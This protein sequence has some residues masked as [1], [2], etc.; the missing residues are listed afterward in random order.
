M[1][2]LALTLL[3]AFFL[4]SS[5]AAAKRSLQGASGLEL[6][7]V[8]LSLP[9]LLLAPW[10]FLYDL[11]SLP[12]VFWG[13]LALLTPLEILAMWLYVRA[14]R[15][16]PLALT[17][18]YLAFTP[19]LVVVTGRL[20][21]DERISTVGLFGILLVVAGSWLLNF[22][23]GGRLSAAR[24]V[25]P[26]RAIVT[27]PGSRMMLVTAALYAMTSV[28]GKAAM[29]WLPPEPF[30]MLYFGLVGGVTL[31]LVTAA[32]PGA[33]RVVRHGPLMVFVVGGLMA[34]M[35][36]TH[37]MALAEVEAAYMIAVKRTSLLFGMAYGAW[38]F[39]ERHLGRH[40]V[41]GAMMVAGVAVIA[42]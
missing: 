16:Y 23:P 19:V 5:D 32:R 36:L 38:L 13:W 6:I 21:L 3:C 31:I 25:A 27:N 20:I 29:Q 10:L 40:L 12:A 24:L 2:W 42:F 33:L 18:P 35:V 14:I 4:A 1:Y 30:G 37:F 8:R 41:A 34:L 28:G 39:G 22:E 26:L 15:D 7:L 17:L 9:G 11:P